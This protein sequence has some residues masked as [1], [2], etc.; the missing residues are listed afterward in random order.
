MIFLCYPILLKI[1]AYPAVRKGLLQ[2]QKDLKQ[3][4][5]LMADVRVMGTVVFADAD[6]KVFCAATA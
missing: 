1:A 2:K 4:P 3:R 5:E 6:I